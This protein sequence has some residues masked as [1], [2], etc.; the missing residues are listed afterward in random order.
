MVG[1]IARL[2][3]RGSKLC[4]GSVSVVRWLLLIVLLVAASPA[5]LFTIQNANWV[6]QLSIDFHFWA[7]RIK[8]PMPVPYLMWMAFGG[9]LLTG[10]LAIPILKAAFFSGSSNDLN[11]DLGNP[12]L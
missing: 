3:G 8:E 5:A 10:M 6:A 4:G 12:T 7:A 9:G 11:S 2:T 1:A